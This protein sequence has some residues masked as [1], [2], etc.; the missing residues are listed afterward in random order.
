MKALFISD[1]HL[2]SDRP[3]TIRAFQH[4]IE[5]A[6]RGANALYILGDLFEHWVGDDDVTP[7]STLVAEALAQLAERGT[8]VHFMPG[9]R[10]FL[11]GDDYAKRAHLKRLAD[12]TLITLNG[13]SV[14]LSHGDM[15]CTDD[16]AYQ[17]FRHQV[18]DPLWQ[19]SFLTRPLPERTQIAAEMR[20][21]SALA[22]AGKPAQIMDV[23]PEAVARLLRDHGYPVLIHGHTHRPAHHLH[24]VDQHNCERWVLSDWH[25][26]APYLIW[27]AGTLE[28]R[29]VAPRA[30][31]GQ[32]TGAGS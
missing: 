11:L 9:N 26:D 32:A 22:N 1:L 7:L 25:A 4:F 3:E 5:V 16:H 18:R 20:R 29:R 14:L 6:A 31:P 19:Q 24:V 12:P 21:Q 10:D 28:A 2:C 30:A 23:N 13:Q 17:Q 15:L 8:A 27:Q